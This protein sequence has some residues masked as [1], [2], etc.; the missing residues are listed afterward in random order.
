MR[1]SEFEKLGRLL[2]IRNCFKTG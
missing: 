2:H 1:E